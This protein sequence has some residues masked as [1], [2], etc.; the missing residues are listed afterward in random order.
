M[1]VRVLVVDDVVTTGATLRAAAGA[2]RSGGACD[3][4]LAAANAALAAAVEAGEDAVRAALAPYRAA[5]VPGHPYGLPEHGTETTIASIDRA[6]LQAVAREHA[7]PDADEDMIPPSPLAWGGAGW[8][9][10]YGV[11]GV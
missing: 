9:G 10:V 8:E 7:V 5:M 6:A 4:V 2:L 11:D 1:T 3:V